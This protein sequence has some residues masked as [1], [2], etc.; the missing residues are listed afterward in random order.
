MFYEHN[1]KIY[2]CFE[3]KE[4][5]KLS[6]GWEGALIH[7]WL[8]VGLN[9]YKIVRPTEFLRSFVKVKNAAV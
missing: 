6:P 5:T 2:I 3:V 4:D 7:D 9:E 1:G 8:C